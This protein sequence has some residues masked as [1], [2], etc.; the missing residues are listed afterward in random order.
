MRGELRWPLFIWG[1]PGVGK[2]FASALLYQRWDARQRVAWWR[3]TDFQAR[4]A[5]CRKN[6]H[7]VAMVEGRPIE[8][9]EE[10]WFRI[11]GQ[12]DMVVF[13]DVGIREPTDTG[14]EVLFMVAEHRRMKPT[15][16]TSNV[17]PAALQKVYDERVASRMLAGT[18]LEMTGADRRVAGQKQIKA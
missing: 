11:L 8:R 2:S 7:A 10:M 5:E 18:V 17:A 4:I 14:F 13:D 1:R 12:Q 6:G 15:V 9:T 3:L 16:Y